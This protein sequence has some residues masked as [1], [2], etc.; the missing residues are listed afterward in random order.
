MRKNLTRKKSVLGR[1]SF[2][3]GSPTPRYII[4]IAEFLRWLRITF[5]LSKNSGLLVDIQ[6]LEKFDKRT[7]SICVVDKRSRKICLS[8]KD[9]LEQSMASLGVMNYTL[10]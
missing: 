9:T 2:C 4:N 7:V 5:N 10:W 3:S 1:E 8:W 6:Q